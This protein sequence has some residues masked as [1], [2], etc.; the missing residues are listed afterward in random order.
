MSTHGTSVCQ[1]VS[2]W[3]TQT[4]YLIVPLHTLSST[5]LQFLWQLCPSHPRKRMSLAALMP[6][7]GCKQRHRCHCRASSWPQDRASQEESLPEPLLVLPATAVSQGL[8][9]RGQ[10]GWGPCLVTS[11]VLSPHTLLKSI[12]IADRHSQS[13]WEQSGCWGWVKALPRKRKLVLQKQPH[14]S[15]NSKTQ[16]AS[17]TTAS[18]T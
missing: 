13:L 18:G 17:V 8:N 9:P 15:V 14:E 1:Q 2:V 4:L 10:V 16:F 12:S 11:V 5:A 6:T 3:V 7:P